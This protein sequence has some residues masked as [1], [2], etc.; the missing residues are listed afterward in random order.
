MKPFF[1]VALFFILTIVLSQCARTGRPEGGPKD[2]EAPLFV[3]A[4][5]AYK[6]T[7][8]NKK[9][10]KLSFNEFVKLKNLN[11]QLLVSPPL[12]NPLLVTPQSTASKYLNLKI[13][14]TLL[15]NTTYIINFGNSIEDNNEGNPLESFK[16]I[17]STGNFI[18]SLSIKGEVKNS[19]L[20][21]K[22]K[23]INILLYKIDSTFNDSIVFNKKPNYVTN[24][25][26]SS[27]FNLTNI[28]EGK[29]FLLALKEKNSDYIFNPKE[30]EIGFY[31]DTIVLPR[32]SVL[33]NN[34][35]I[36][37]ENLPY[38][39]K[40]GKEISKGKIAFGYEGKIDSL[41]I[42]VV[43]KTPENFK[44]I[45]K[46]E[47]DK[48]TLNFW[49]TPFEADSLNFIV[50]N[51]KTIDSVT[52]KLRKKK[53]DSLIISSSISRT[54]H[55]RDTL[56]IKSTTPIVS[57]D[58]SKIK[59]IDKDSVTVSYT[60]YLSKKENKFALIFDKKPKQKYS[61]KMLPE[62]VF[63]IYNQK[64]D[65]L[66]FSFSTKEIEDYGRITVDIENETPHQLIIEI[67]EGEK[68]KNLVE[69]HFVKN[70]KKLVFNLLEPNTY[71]IRA[72]I[73]VNKNNKWDTGNYLLNLQPEKIIYYEEPLKLRA[74]YYLDKNVL[75]IKN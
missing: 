19:F 38:K 6:T 13:L 40:R 44:S 75:R 27:L 5:P 68:K 11:K 60:N 56:F 29:Y 45:S 1:R 17:F 69:K 10:I 62:S 58:T 65:T 9:E 22:P 4:N 28:K 50:S 67:L 24:S 16:Y 36:F 23:N 55:L 70:S 49:F 46:F 54:L 26:D 3:T 37:K 52:V 2:E 64:N 47:L 30:D 71:Y 31:S 34:I 12:K 15:K 51:N 66:N 7:N 63:D 43:S 21:D 61:L 42:D 72:T 25:L 33:K 32:D 20:A 74:N 53:I 59:L 57:I 8:F 35:S 39:F 73:D 14:D 41:R 18:D 48:D